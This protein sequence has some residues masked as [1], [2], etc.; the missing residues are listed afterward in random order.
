MTSCC[1]IL[2][3][4]HNGS[5]VHCYVKYHIWTSYSSSLFFFCTSAVFSFFSVINICTH[6]RYHTLFATC[7]YHVSPLDRQRMPGDMDLRYLFPALRVA[8]HACASTTLAFTAVF[9]K[10]V[11]FSHHLSSSAAWNINSF[12]IMPPCTQT[13]YTVAR[14]RL[15]L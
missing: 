12:L 8:P 7:T 10:H 2:S 1:T 5:G 9:F 3:L 14:C 15:E 11:S 4:C 6:A 13:M